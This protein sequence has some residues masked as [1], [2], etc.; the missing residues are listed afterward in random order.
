MQ[1]EVFMDGHK[2]NYTHAE[3]HTWHHIH[4][5]AYKHA[6]PSEHMKVHMWRHE[7]RSVT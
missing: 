3:G 4:G 6:R 7:H 5:M 2:Q 1:S